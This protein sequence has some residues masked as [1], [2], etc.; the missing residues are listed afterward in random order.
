MRP[1]STALPSWVAGSARNTCARPYTP[2]PVPTTTVT[3]RAAAWSLRTIR[4]RTLFLHDTLVRAG[5]VGKGQARELA[6]EPLVNARG[7]SPPPGHAPRAAL[8]GPGGHGQRRLG[9]AFIPSAEAISAAT[10]RPLK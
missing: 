8:T 10:S 1:F 5:R 3:A 6:A 7:R 9:G 2:A 4:R